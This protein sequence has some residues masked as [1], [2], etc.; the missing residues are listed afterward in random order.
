MENCN[1]KSRTAARK[2][3]DI[4]ADLLKKLEKETRRFIKLK[5]RLLVT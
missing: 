4:N 2:L 5:N 1:Y 3:I